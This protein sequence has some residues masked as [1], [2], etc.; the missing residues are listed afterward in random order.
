MSEGVTAGQAILGP[1]FGT[2]A[3][4]RGLLLGQLSEPCPLDPKMEPIHRWGPHML[5]A[6]GGRLRLS[7]SPIGASR[8]CSE[9]IAIV[10]AWI[11]ATHNQPVFLDS[12]N[13]AFSAYC[14]VHLKIGR[15]GGWRL[16][17][18]T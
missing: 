13:R 18:E 4:R 10:H 8:Y 11:A 9:L 2:R 15:S 7:A 3:H 16:Q 17:G 14:T 6:T 1:S 5:S 12:P